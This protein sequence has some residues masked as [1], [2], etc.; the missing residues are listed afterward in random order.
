VESLARDEFVGEGQ[1]GHSPLI[2]MDANELLKTRLPQQATSHRERTPALSTSCTSPPSARCTEIL[3]CV[4]QSVALD[5]VF[6]IRVD[7][8][9]IHLRV[10][11]LHGGLEPVERPRLGEL[12]SP[13]NRT[14]RFSITS[15][16]LDERRREPWR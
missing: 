10:D 2:Q 11:V 16:S 6:D 1:P 8:N 15:P 13:M 9:A 12:N 5:R 4:E 3:D 14:A 7:K